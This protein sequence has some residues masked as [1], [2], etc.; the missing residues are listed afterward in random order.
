[1]TD[2]SAVELLRRQPVGPGVIALEMATPSGFEAQPGQFVLVHAGGV[3]GRH[4]TISSPDA[5]DSFEITVDVSN[6]SAMSN[7]LADRTPTDVIDIAGP[8]GQTFYDG[9]DAVAIGGG[10]GIGAAVGVAERARRDRNDV[11]L[12]AADRLVHEER[13][14]RLAAGGAAV[15]FVEREL[16]AA[17]GEAKRDS[18]VFVFG[19][20]DFVD[21]V[22]TAATRAGFDPDAFAIE[23]YGRR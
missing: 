17:L 20:R 21:R 12:I 2:G 13:L 22:R 11:T 15:Y 8:F 1:M 23:S 10:S 6:E 19:F 16:R 18:Q 14:S 9:G 3:G 7:W 4:Y 5:E